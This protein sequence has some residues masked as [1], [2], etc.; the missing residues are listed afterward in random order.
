VNEAAQL[1]CTRILA[2][3]DLMPKYVDI[4]QERNPP[5]KKLM[6]ATLVMATLVS[7][8]LPAAPARATDPATCPDTVFIGEHPDDED[9]PDWTDNVQGVAHD[10]DH[11]FFTTTD[12]L[13]KFPVGF[14]LATTIDADDPPAGVQIVGIPQALTDLGYFHFGD[15][16]QVG[17]FLLMPI[18]DGN[19]DDDINATPAIAVFRASDLGYVGIKVTGQSSAAWVAYNR[20]LGLLYSS[21][22]NTSGSDPLY[23][24]TLDLDLLAS[25]NDVAG[26]ITFLDRFHLLEANGGELNPQLGDF[27]QGGVFTPWGDLY[28]V[29]GSPSDDPG[30]V[31][32]GIHLFG[33]DGKLIA[34]SQNGSGSF[35]YEYHPGFPVGEEPEGVDWWNRSIGASS[36]GITGQLH[37]IMLDNDVS[38]DDLFFKHYDVTYCGLNGDS[39]GDGLTD[40][41]EGY[42]LGT[43]PFAADTDNDGL[44]DGV[45][46]NK[47]GTDPLNKDSDGDGILDGAEDTDGDGLTDGAEVSTYGTDPLDV[48]TDDDLLSDGL[49]VAYGTNPLVA[50]TDGDGLVD[51]KDVEFIQHAVLALPASSFKPPAGGTRKAIISILNDAQALAKTGNVTGAVQKLNDLRK[52]LDGCGGVPDL[53]DWIRNCPQQVTV[54]SLVDLLIANLAGP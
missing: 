49:E 31:R 17:G 46:V 28:I 33:A 54:R 39:D 35:N 19:D 3:L 18:E 34:E 20:H 43:D 38:E 32:G 42:L 14:D 25:T 26:S 29:S 53:N 37:V 52:H 45:E 41:D 21:D 22:G 8:L 9:D 12:L 4:S 11:W 36:P 15:L 13:L 6:R 24:Y 48:D 27:M 10:D 1:I 2:A 47:L 5:M 40:G 30:D 7:F 51:G 50:D 44:P 23:R 16:D